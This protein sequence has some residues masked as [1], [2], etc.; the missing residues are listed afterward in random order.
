[1]LEHLQKKKSI[2]FF[3]LRVIIMLACTLVY[4]CPILCWAY[5][6]IYRPS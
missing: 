4:R 3:K 1:M 5:A 6:K 2:E